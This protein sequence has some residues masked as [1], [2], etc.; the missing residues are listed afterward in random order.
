VKILAI[1][2]AT[3]ASS[4]AIGEDDRLLAMNLRVDRTGHLSFLTPAIDMCFDQ[5]GWTPRDID[6]V[7]VD[8]GPGP[9]TG[10]RIGIAA[11]QAV[12]ASLG[13]PIIPVG[14]LTA[15]AWRAA[16][17]RRRIW[18]V[19]D[20]RRNQVATQAFMPVPGGVV[21]D[22]PAQVVTVNEFQAL[23]ASDG[24]ETLV[25]GDVAAAGDGFLRGVQRAK[26]GRPRYPTADIILEIAHLRAQSGEYSSVDEIR[27][28][29]MREPDAAIQWTE[30]RHEG[31]W[32]GSEPS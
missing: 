28:R 17:G 10:L 4:V 5:V 24:I 26:H 25:V 18:P 21:A 14:S 19:V 29:Y 15:L 7:A 13:V 31:V 8:V 1:D 2:T 16:T 32:P 22:G 20:M 11:A 9:Y 12:A 6:A 23:L 27:P 30:F 3:P